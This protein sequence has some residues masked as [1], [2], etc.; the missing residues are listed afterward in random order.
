MLLLL[1][2]GIKGLRKAPS[3]QLRE[4]EDGGQRWLHG[5]VSPTVEGHF[6]RRSVVYILEGSQEGGL[7]GTEAAI[8]GRKEDSPKRHQER[9]R[10]R[11]S[12]RL[13][14]IP[15]PGLGPSVQQK[16][17]CKGKIKEI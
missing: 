14:A 11:H 1:S 4:D 9:T 17:A 6:V 15:E 8:S 7:G 13:A 2:A 12:P 10:G 16:P 5:P 3:L